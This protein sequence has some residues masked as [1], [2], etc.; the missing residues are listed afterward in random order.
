M[1]KISKSLSESDEGYRHSEYQSMIAAC[2]LSSDKA[3]KIISVPTGSGKTWIQGLISK[4]YCL[5]D[6]PV[7]IIEPNE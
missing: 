6:Q 1:I 2:S 4:Y 3:F 7:T 5:K